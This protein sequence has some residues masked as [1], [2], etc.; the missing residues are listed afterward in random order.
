MMN[1]RKILLWLPALF[2]LLVFA[3][4]ALG[5]SGDQIIVNNADT[6]RQTSVSG[7][8][9]LLNSISGVG[10]RIVLQYANLMRPVGLS[11]IP[12]ALQTAI[13]LV[14]PR[15]VVQYANLMRHHDLVAAPGPLQ[16]LLSQASARVILLYANQNRALS[17]SYP[18]AMFGD[19][20]APQISAIA[21]APIAADRVTISWVTD[22]FA[23]STV[24]YGEQPGV[25][26]HTVSDP[27]YVKGHALTLTGLTPGVPIYYRVRSTDQSS[28]MGQSSERSFTPQVL[29]FLPI[30]LN[31]R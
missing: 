9:D 21:A 27:L 6:V 13:I 16:T 5:Q 2:L 24:V 1:G 29:T 22:E 10:P 4:P 17:L 31:R 12:N 8:Q 28:N 18:A 20:T 14:P 3:L 26:T 25:Y 11:A 23:D 30:V 7:A 15:I 19:T